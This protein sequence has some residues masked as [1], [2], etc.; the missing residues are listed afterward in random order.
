MGDITN[1]TIGVKLYA[2]KTP[3]LDGKKG[4]PELCAE[5]AKKCLESLILHR[6]IRIKLLSRNKDNYAVCQA[7]TPKGK[8]CFCVGGVKP[9]DISHEMARSGY[10][11]LF[12]GGGP[13]GDVSIFVI[14]ICCIYFIKTSILF[15][16]LLSI[17]L[18]TLYDFF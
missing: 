18:T 11:T 13:V 14:C 5:D 8:C 12:T 9:I 17:I 10:A 3:T 7:E 6:V 15:L 16:F 2:I 4:K 1:R